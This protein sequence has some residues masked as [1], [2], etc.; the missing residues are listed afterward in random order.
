MSVLG[1]IPARGGSKGVPRKNVRLLGGKPLIGWACQAA[2]GSTRISRLVCSTDSPE[3][4]EVCKQFGVETPFLRPPELATD[5]ALVVDV[6]H[7]MLMELDPSG[8]NFSYVCL[9]QATSPFVTSAI[10][11]EAIATAIEKNADTV[12]SGTLCGMQHPS[13]MFTLDQERRVRWL[14]PES[15]R[16]KRRQDFEP[17]YI[18]RGAV[19]VF[20]AAMIRQNRSLYGERIFAVETDE[21]HATTIDTELD[22]K[23]AEFF[24]K[25][26][27][28]QR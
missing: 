16:M 21:A 11:D 3:I 8:T 13:T 26:G 2:K 20:R 7:H 9:A 24:I 23:L 5:K 17:I 27:L 6:L 4:A 28:V 12:I 1:I 25:E 22:F 10:L 19:Y 18:R 14:L 15:G